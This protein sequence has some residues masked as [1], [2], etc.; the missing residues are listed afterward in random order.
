MKTLVPATSLSLAAVAVSLGAAPQT[1]PPQTGTWT[2]RLQDTGRGTTA[3]GGS[4]S[5]S[6]RT[7]RPLRDVHPDRGSP[8][9]W[10]PAAENWTSPGTVRFSVRR[11]A[12]EV[13]FEGAS[14]PGAGPGTYRFTPH[15]D[16]VT[17]MARAGY[18]GLDS[19]ALFRLTLHDVSRASSPRSRR[20]AIRT[21]TSRISSACGSTASTRTTSR[22][23]AT[24]AT[25]G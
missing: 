17:A 22:D 19:D 3:N 2:A 9:P 20:P 10:A 4:R 11:D 25:T 5:S 14:R 1:A 7:Q 16:Y 6:S 8:G 18:R 21:P 13:D 12:G 23:C 24:P 15:A